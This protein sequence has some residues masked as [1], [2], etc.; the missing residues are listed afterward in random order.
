MYPDTTINRHSILFSV[1]LVLFIFPKDVSFPASFLPSHS[2]STRL[3]ADFGRINSARFSFTSATAPGFVTNPP[4]KPSIVCPASKTL[5]TPKAGSGRVPGHDELLPCHDQQTARTERRYCQ[6]GGEVSISWRGMFCHQGSGVRASTPLRGGQSLGGFE[7]VPLSRCAEFHR[8]VFDL[9]QELSLVDI[10]TER[11]VGEVV[12]SADASFP[13][14]LQREWC[15]RLS[16]KF[17]A[18]SYLKI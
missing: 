9:L 18:V 10:T 3:P 11:E 17:Y 14:V 4:F 15:P 12:P 1:G 13:G 6:R 5:R 2:L 16:S 8:T 7:G